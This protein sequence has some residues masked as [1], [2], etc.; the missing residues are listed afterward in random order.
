MPAKLYTSNQARSAAT[1]GPDGEEAETRRHRLRRRWDIRD[2][3]VRQRYLAPRDDGHEGR[4]RRGWGQDA[5]D[6]SQNEPRDKRTGPGM[7]SR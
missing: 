6:L 4:L 2:A 1:T 5:E 3:G 7:L